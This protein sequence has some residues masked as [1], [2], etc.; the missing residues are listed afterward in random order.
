MSLNSETVDSKAMHSYETASLTEGFPLLQLPSVLLTKVLGYLP[1]GQVVLLRRVCQALKDAAVICISKKLKKAGA[2]GLIQQNLRVRAL[3]QLYLNQSKQM[4]AKNHTGHDYVKTFILGYP[5]IERLNLTQSI[6]S[7]SN[8]GERFAERFPAMDGRLVTVGIRIS[9]KVALRVRVPVLQYLQELEFQRDTLPHNVFASRIYQLIV[10]GVEALIQKI[11]KFAN[12]AFTYVTYLP[13]LE[14]HPFETTTY[15]KFIAQTNEPLCS[16][17]LVLRGTGH[18]QNTP[19]AV[20]PKFPELGFMVRKAEM[21][22]MFQFAFQ[23]I[24]DSI[25]RVKS[26]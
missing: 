24:D 6:F 11:I 14:N 17:T 1:L 10:H 16:N 15:D 3:I 9:R 23:T 5:A 13:K 21:D 26:L 7:M 25:A 12:G 22:G 2:E 19:I 4:N 18:G 20:C 8:L